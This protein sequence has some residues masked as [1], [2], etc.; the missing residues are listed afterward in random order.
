LL[1]VVMVAMV[2]TP[3]VNAEKIEESPESQTQDLIQPE[4]LPF[5]PIQK[6]LV[7]EQTPEP[8]QTTESEPFL[9]KIEG[10]P[11]PSENET[12]PP[13]PT[14]TNGIYIE[15]AQTPSVETDSHDV[16]SQEEA[17][18][19]LE[20]TSS[21]MPVCN[22]LQPPQTPIQLEEVIGESVLGGT[23]SWSYHDTIGVPMGTSDG[24]T[25][26]AYPGC[27]KFTPSD[28][29]P[30]APVA[31]VL[32][33]TD[34][35]VHT[36][37]NTL[38][39]QALGIYGLSATVY[40]DGD[41]AGFQ[42]ALTTG[43]PWDLVIWSGENYNAGGTGVT[44]DLL[45]YLQG[46]GKLIATYWQQL[47]I[48]LDPLWAEMGF[49]YI[50]NY[51]SPVFPCYWWEPTHHIFTTPESAPEWINRVVNSG[52]SQGTYLEPTA[53]G[54]APAGYTLPPSPN[55]AGI[56][57]RNDNKAIYKGIR[58]VS[59]DADDD[60]DGKMDGA[61]LW[62]DMMDF[63]LTYGVQL[64][65]ILIYA[66]DGIHTS[67]NTFVDQALDALGLPYTA[68]YDQD[69]AGFE[70]DLVSNGPWDLVIL[71]NDYWAPPTSTLDAI[72]TYVSGGGRL[73]L[74]TWTVSWYPAHPLWTTLGVTWASSDNSPPDPVY[75]W[76]PDHQ[77]FNFPE[78][79]PQFTNP[80]AC[81]YGTYAEK[82][83]PI[84]GFQAVAGHVAAPAPNEAALVPG[85][86]DR[87]IFK[88]FLD[89][90]FDQNNDGD[91]KPDG[92][93]LW[94]NMIS[95]FTLSPLILQ[96]SYQSQFCSFVGQE[97]YYPLTLSNVGPTP[98][99][100]DISATGNAWPVDFLGLLCK[101]PP[102]VQM[103]NPSF[104]TGDFTGWNTVD[105]SVPFS[106]L[107]VS[108]AGNDP[109]GSF[110][111]SAPTDGTFSLQTG[112]DGNGPGHILAGQDYSVS[113][114]GET[115]LEFDYRAGWDLQ[116]IPATID[117][118]FS[119][120]IEPAG[121]GPP[122]QTNL[123][124]TAVANT[125]VSD[126]GI[127]HGSVNLTSFAGST[128]YIE[129]DWW[130]PEASSGPAFFELDNLMIMSTNGYATL[131]SEGFEGGVMPPTGWSV[132]DGAA[133]TRHWQV[134]DSATFPQFVHSG[135]WGGWVN[136][137]VADQ[138]EWLFSPN[139]VIP[140]NALAATLEFWAI[141]DTNFPAATVIL[142]AIEAGG[143]YTDTLWD[144]IADET[145]PVFGKNLISIDL[146]AY[147]GET[148]HLA[149]Q[150]VGNDGESFGL[151]DINVTAVMPPSNTVGP[152]PPW[153]SVD[154]IVRV[155]VPPGAV[156]GDFD[157]ADITASTSQIINEQF[158]G[159]FPPAG[160]TVMQY[161]NPGKVWM[162]SDSGY[163][164]PNEAS[165]QG[166]Y[167]IAD[168]DYWFPDTNTG[169]RTPS[170]S[171]VGY[172]SAQLEF[173][174]YYS[175]IG[176]ADYAEVLVSTDSGGTWTQI[177]LYTSN[178]GPNA[179][180][181]LSLNAFIGQPDVMV[182][183]HY[184]DENWDW[185]W[186][187]D[188]VEIN[189]GST[190]VVSNVAQ[191]ETIWPY[192]V[193]WSD[194]MES[195]PGPWEATG[196]WHQ[197]QDG[198]SPYPNSYSPI[199][200]WWYGQ[201]G[202]GDYDNGFRNFGRLET[203]WIDLTGVSQ[204]SLSFAEWYETE[205]WYPTYDQRW[206]QYNSGSGWVNIQQLPEDESN[207][208]VH[209]TIDLTPYCGQIIKFGFWFDT[210]DDEANDY[211]GWYVD[212]VYVGPH[213]VE[214][215]PDYQSDTD[216]WTADVDYT[217]TVTNVGSLP[218]NYDLSAFGNAWP[219]TFWD[220]FGSTPIMQTG[221]IPPGGSIDIIA[222]VS[223]PFGVANGTIDLATIQVTSQNNPG[224]TWD[225]AQI[226]TTALDP[227]DVDLS[228]PAQTATGYVGGY[229]D[230][231]LTIDNT[232]VWSDS[233]N[234]GVAGN[235]WP[236]TFWQIIN[237]Q[238]LVSEQ[239]EGAF[240]PAGWTT[241]DYGGTGVWTRNDEVPDNRPN[242]AGGI[243]YCAD[244]DS[245]SPYTQD[246]MNTGLRTPSFSLVGYTIAQL[247]F[248]TSFNVFSTPQEFANVRVSINGGDTWSVIAHY[249]TSMSPNGPGT[250][251]T[252]DLS[253]FIGNS[254]VIVEFFYGNAWYDWWWEVD[255]V[256]ITAINALGPITSIGP[257]PAGGSADFIARV[258]IPALAPP[259]SSDIGTITVT[260][261]NDP[262]FTWDQATVQTFCA[263]PYNVLLSPNT[264]TKSD[265]TGNSVDF[266]LTIENIGVWSDSYGLTVTGNAWPTTFWDITGTTQ[267]F[268]T[269]VM[270][271][272]DTLNF[273]VRV[274]IPA[275]LPPGVS[276]TAT[277]RATSVSYFYVWDEA[278]VH[279]HGEPSYWFQANPPIQTR[280]GWTGEY[281]DH[282]ISVTNLGQSQ[283]V[284]L[285]MFGDFQWPITFWNLDY[286]GNKNE[287]T[288]WIGPCNPGQTIQFIAEVR[289]PRVDFGD[290]DLVTIT[291][292]S[293]GNRAFQRAVQI[294][295]TT[296][297]QTPYF[298]NF[299][300]GVF[301]QGITDIDWTTDN[302]NRCGLNHVTSFSGTHSMYLSEGQTSITSCAF[303]LRGLPTAIAS[304]WI[305]R[306]GGF[307]DQ[308]EAGE[309]L[310]VEY[311]NPAGYWIQLGYYPGDGPAGE[312]F[313]PVFVLPHAAL[314]S[315]F[316]L[317]FRETD[318]DG[319]E[320]DQDYWHIDDVYIG[321]P[322]P[323]FDLTPNNLQ[324]GG[325]QGGLVQST[326][327]IN[328]NALHPDIYT[329][330]VTGNTWPTYAF[331]PVLEDNFDDGNFNGW[332]VVDEGT[333]SAPSNWFNDA[334][335]RLGQNN[336]IYSY[337]GQAMSGT[338]V[339]NGYF[340][341]P[342]YILQADIRS[343]DNDGIG[344]MG[345]YTNPQNYYRFHWSQQDTN[346]DK[347][348]TKPGFQRRVLDK[349]VNGVWTV[350]ESDDIPYV[351]GQW[352]NVEMKFIGDKIQV[353][354]DNILIFDVT[355]SSLASGAIALY[356][357]GNQNSYFDNV[358][359]LGTTTNQ[360]G[361]IW[362]DNSAD[363]IVVVETPAGASIGDEDSASI[364]VTSLL[365]P[366]VT[367][368]SQLITGV[369]SVHNLD[370]NTWH[371][372]IQDAVNQADPN[373]HIWA[374][375]FVYEESVIV[376][377]PLTIHGVDRETTIV[378]G[379]GSEGGLGTSNP[380]V[381]LVHA[382]GNANGEPLRSQL[383]AFPDINSV[384]SFLATSATP[385]L[386]NLMPYDA[387]IAWNDAHYADRVAMG[388]VLADYVDAG[389]KVILT[390]FNWQYWDTANYGL[391][392]R[393]R[394]QQYSPFYSLDTSNHYGWADLGTFDASHPIMTGVT[395]ASD[396]YRDYV[397]LNP[398]ATL[399][400]SWND[401][402][403]FVATKG[404]VVGINSYPGSAR[405]WTGD[406]DVI[407]HNSVIWLAGSSEYV[408]HATSNGV[409]IDGFT[410]QNG[411][412]GVF[413]DNVGDC[414]VYNNLIVN[415]INGIQSVDS[416]GNTIAN[417]EIIGLGTVVSPTIVINEFNTDGTDW[418]ELYNY[419]PTQD[420][421]GWTWYWEDDRDTTYQGTYVIPA[422]Y[423]IPQYGCVIIS[424]DSG[425]DT[426]TTWYM[427][428]NMM[429]DSSATGVA[430]EIRNN[431]GEGVDFFKTGVDATTPTA[432]GQWFA[433]N[434]PH[435]NPD[436]TAWRHQDQDTDSGTDWTND[437]IQETPGALNPGQTGIGGSHFA[438]VGISVQGNGYLNDFLDD[439]STDTGQWTYLGA[440][441]RTNGYMQVCPIGGGWGQGRF[442]QAIDT[443]FICDFDWR[444][445]DGNGAD[446]L[447]MMFYKDMAYSPGAGGS[448]GFDGS[449]GYGIEFDQY[450]GNPGDPGAPHIGLIQNSATNHLIAVIDPRVRDAT[451][452]HAQVRV[453]PTSNAINVFIDYSTSPIISWTGVID[454][455]FSGFGFSAATGGLNDNHRV[456][457]VRIRWAPGGNYI[458]ENLVQNFGTG[459]AL[460]DAA[461]NLI[462]HND[463]IG[464]TLQAFDNMADPLNA[465]DDGY[466]SGG[467]FWSDY[468]GS[469]AGGDGIGDT[470]YVIDADSQD[471]YPL[472]GRSTTYSTGPSSSPSEE[473]TPGPGT[474]TTGESPGPKETS[475][476]PIPL[477][478]ELPLDIPIGDDTET[479]SET[480]AKESAPVETAQEQII[481]SSGITTEQPVTQEII[482]IPQEPKVHS[483][484]L[485]PSAIGII[486]LLAI[487]TIVILFR[488]KH[489][490]SK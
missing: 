214:L 411:M 327:T 304:C 254:A 382:D 236:I 465:W 51:Q 168:S 430:G 408:F 205:D 50:A 416:G 475:T 330:D 302:P 44:T 398:G 209:R 291:I 457:N 402:E 238:T 157:L 352:Y 15:P 389:G 260:S 384:D 372:T 399:V 404:S 464:N 2:A 166:L 122:L 276:D 207:T 170:F 432:P 445:G 102:N 469:D 251:I 192:D 429:W 455:S 335:V 226:E 255:N 375:P 487:T 235:V 37:P 49:T 274:S 71:G 322:N 189:D 290:F 221:I 105:L 162:R 265:L 13:S 160:W 62:V 208:W 366:T 348:W 240:P 148:L 14:G 98:G 87:T 155:T 277:I 415:C 281:V 422:G 19:P 231:F 188:N 324:N 232:G 264:Q 341:A 242:Y 175:D 154:F 171:L 354:I 386:A 73:I 210:L 18:E 336:N 477:T 57:I 383:L 467:N 127:Q 228:P 169:L 116:M 288:W 42:T 60:M 54:Y 78:S 137:E 241:I 216:Y 52:T 65:D 307:S 230:H 374:Y 347:D 343:T 478:E 463:F 286:Y 446:G 488:R 329:V 88:S 261:Q 461:G 152:I 458:T 206:I 325:P 24:G 454:T 377:K 201:D 134:L 53:T 27:Y 197:V 46:G 426:P 371:E 84:A 409:H 3:L 77:F 159:P 361:P 58:D 326:F 195:G 112:F 161:G 268:S 412:T 391:A 8:K 397:G 204:A 450:T 270:A 246:W 81:G 126:T 378:D 196:F 459:V 401:G 194:D 83:E 419:G 316:Q 67:P 273:I 96:P 34:D 253:P 405:Q 213:A 315:S 128:V 33:Y 222:R 141:S 394:D 17:V 187:I 70:T 179:H 9:E 380:D 357:W 420:M 97:V 135:A 244:A 125:Y 303:Y 111:D 106:P 26:L 294:R 186:E 370:R 444:I 332:M 449:N 424:E 481:D 363:F 82:V 39:Q 423:T 132:T 119:V 89:G 66:D 435:L 227:Y 153:G 47:S 6:E 479:I 211:T 369:Y 239:F 177:A 185:F 198:V 145:W 373:N 103:Q 470:P 91:G 72:N 247:D 441:S 203:P 385:T 23:I 442:S 250:H 107:Q 69:F 275:G 59:T 64:D 339:V 163:S 245:D 109:W 392:G 257:I 489:K 252:I 319:I 80:S 43:G 345:R 249:K 395:S 301:G 215:T 263:S 456:D 346:W 410:I 11:S 133:S 355:D 41:Y 218:D 45:N 338:Y 342:D 29:C 299:E 130:V 220:S 400:A 311:K 75:W 320:V 262:A 31:D 146:T 139:F 312:I 225:T 156:P 436:S 149:W 483:S 180:T 136:Y 333:I 388:N 438:G 79:V 462:F 131:L 437:I 223:I 486:A 300:S 317:R 266:I 165:G 321:A 485:M 340:S 143:A 256:E 359:V 471:D 337:N 368:T 178:Q 138:D 358:K 233:Y 295:T 472:I 193:P 1:V 199:T 482:T 428:S 38:V 278:Q 92:V 396:R 490:I 439:F 379:S 28:P 376:N 271:V 158:E 413:L 353:Y 90:Q 381:L 289:V 174:Q 280:F 393:M 48:P 314:H 364:T 284:Y 191:I 4:S 453:D 61:E 212:D 258:A 331:L 297:L 292:T 367:E 427:D 129:F 20:H 12:T 308:P 451:W 140:G 313:F 86:G 76:Q 22:S 56:V 365:N 144:L 323:N 108:G 334:G 85:N 243:G 387:V 5:G 440:A 351:I 176:N 40:V 267:I 279:T 117:R 406:V 30:F 100:F 202:T 360:I 164:R 403:E 99:T 473:P 219:V 318:T 309:D 480:P 93:E 114:L 110:F 443:P 425:I 282:I 362:P 74:H 118:T 217:F 184:D 150:Y 421:S 7:E 390:T 115:F 287:Q 63:M 113:L 35:W 10:E 229:G 94:I 328:N 104:E 36:T 269:G 460:H 468:G 447:V 181:I 296:S 121:G 234:L 466:P 21:S 183:F 32:V 474:E 417:C 285:P 293:E 448:I 248:D 68:H 433:P 407:I 484:M 305:Q 283:D 259:G 310:F 151:D 298:N 306:G 142:Y 120:L 356:S 431:L 167:A 349:C 16:P 55:N 172:S 344:L 190:Y 237:T 173:D 272:G 452:H 182:E 414:D 476:E 95:S 101:V 147:A 434:I 224:F 418:V 123:M 124:L 200:S 25:T 350:L